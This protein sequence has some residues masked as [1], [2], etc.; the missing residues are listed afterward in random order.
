MVDEQALDAF[1]ASDGEVAPA[2]DAPESE[3]PVSEPVTE[4][5]VEHEVP[6]LPEGQ[7][8]FDRAYVE[9]LRKEAANYRERAKKYNE[10]F[11]GYEA[12]AVEEWLSLASTLKADPKA[13]AQRFAELAD[14]IR[15]QYGD[16]AA[17]AVE[18]AVAADADAN[19]AAD[20]PLTRAEL[21]AFMAEREK[22][23]EISR[24]VAK[25]EADATELGYKRGTEDYDLLLW[26]ASRLKNG[27][28]H[29]AHAK[30]KAREQAIYDRK[31]AE[32][33]GRP[34]PTVP[35]PGTPASSER[36][37]RTFDEANKALDE[38]LSSQG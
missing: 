12:E 16:A 25:I 7:D 13:A 19:P 26:E 8:T 31:L 1:L 29:E 33:G 10:V 20:K 38:W 5:E 30:I 14:A 23:A 24:R 9:K 32:L 6:T 27:S 36:E 37:L 35:S 3:A 2:A 21:E 28:I 22:E 15:E 17:D 18:E 4:A 34:N 11:E